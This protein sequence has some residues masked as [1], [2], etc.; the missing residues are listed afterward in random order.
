M[1]KIR[2]TILLAIL[3]FL[4]TLPS[5]HAQ[6]TMPHIEEPFS[7]AAV[8][9]IPQSECEALVVIYNETGGSEWRTYTYKG[10]DTLWLTNDTPCRWTGVDCQDGHVSQL[11]FYG[12]SYIAHSFAYNLTG[13]LPPEIANLTQLTSIDLNYNKLNSI[14]PEIGD[15]NNL[16]F[17]D[18]NGNPLDSIPSEIGNLNNLTTLNLSGNALSSIPPEI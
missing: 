17:L 2:T 4:A 7:C 16:T 18:L 10:P 8:S 15:L 6:A 3:T 13:N 12:Y 11:D 5:Q 1:S 14:P 9:E